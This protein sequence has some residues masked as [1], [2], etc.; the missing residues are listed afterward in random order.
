M[1]AGIAVGAAG[2]TAV[3]FDVPRGAC[4]C[5]VHAFGNPAQFPFAKA[6][7]TRLR[8]LR[9][10]SCWSFSVIFTSTVS[11]WCSRASTGPT[12]PAHLTPCAGVARERRGVAVIDRTMRARLW[13][14]WRRQAFAACGSISKPTTCRTVRSSRCQSRAS[15]QP[16]SKSADSAGMF[17]STPA[18]PP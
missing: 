15:T 2:R 9:S 7:S 6:R 14:R 18:P 3:D 13:K 17:R 16:P 5:H 4:D 1:R 10:S 12:M 8:R 11:W